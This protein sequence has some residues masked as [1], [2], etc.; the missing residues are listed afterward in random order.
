MSTNDE[1]DEKQPKGVS[2]PSGGSRAPEVAQQGRDEV[3]VSK[4]HLPD[5]SERTQVTHPPRY[6]RQPGQLKAALESGVI[7]LDEYQQRVLEGLSATIAIPVKDGGIVYEPDY[8]LR[9][10]YLQFVTE[11]VEGMP[12]KRQE[13][14]SRKLTTT[15]D[16]VAQAKKSPAFARSLMRQLERIVSDSAERSKK[17]G[18]ENGRPEPEK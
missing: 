2:L 6:L 1:N 5:G 16:L 9:L 10:K 17:G 15:E 11:T 7:D 18:G 14:V 12:V 3:S 4:D 13:I 8:S